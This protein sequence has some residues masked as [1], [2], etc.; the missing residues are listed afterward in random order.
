MKKTN[1]KK[2]AAMGIAGGILMAQ[3]HVDAG[4]QNSNSN[5]GSQNYYTADAMDSSSESTTKMSE[6]DLLQKLSPETKAVYQS[7]GKDGKELAL[8][9]ANQSCKGKNDC[10]G[11]NSCK[12]KDN[13]C[14]GQ[15]GC[16]GQSKGPF[17]DK[18]MAVMVAAKH[19]AGKR[20]QSMANG[21][22]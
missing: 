5:R 19:M 20:L 18:D 6:S 22:S 4:Y 12:T 8:K 13:A 16:K 17:A 11:Q 1:L 9:L 10:K 15:G 3:A 21:N 2:L 14:A 7:L